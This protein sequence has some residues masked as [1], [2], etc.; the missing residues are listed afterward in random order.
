MKNLFTKNRNFEYSAMQQQGPGCFW[1]CDPAEPVLSVVAIVYSHMRMRKCKLI[2]SC[3][4]KEM[5]C[6]QTKAITD[7][8]LKPEVGCLLWCLKTVQVGMHRGQ[9]VSNYPFTQ[10]SD[11]LEI[12]TR[13]CRISFALFNILW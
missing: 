11:Q 10:F 1:R 8:K 2:V 5:K 13:E 6:Y 12:L 4:V 3:D 7:P 9:V